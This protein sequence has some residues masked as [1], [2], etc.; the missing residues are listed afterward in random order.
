MNFVEKSAFKILSFFVIIG[1]LAAALISFQR[2][3]VENNAKTVEMVYDYKN[4]IERASVENTSTDDLFRLYKNSGITSLAVYEETVENLQNNGKIFVYKGSQLINPDNDNV[5]ESDHIYLQQGTSEDSQSVFEDLKKSLKLRIP[6]E[7][8][9]II[10][11]NNKIT[12]DVKANYSQFIHLPLGIFKT[13]LDSV[14]KA[15]FMAVIRPLNVPHMS[16]EIAE[17]LIEIID[18]SQNISA[19]LFQGKQAFGYK[20]QL[21]YFTNEL[22]KRNIP[23]A[24]IEAQNQLGFERQDGILNMAKDTNYNIIRV[25]A[26]PKDELIKITPDEAESRFYISDIER[27]IRMNLFPSY[28]FPN[29][30]KTL[31]ETNA[32]YISGVRD[33]LLE[34]GFNIGK[35][36]V[37]DF[38]FPNIVLRS[39]ALLGAISLCVITSI[40][41]LPKIRKFWFILELLIFIIFEALYVIKGSVIPLQIA[42][43]GSACSVPV[44]IVTLFI[45]YCLNIKE[46]KEKNWFKLFTESLIILWISGILSLL[47]ALFVSGLLGDVRF[48]VEMQIFRGVKLT[49]IL[50]IILISIIYIQKFPFFGKTITNTDEFTE[51]LKKFCNVP[52]KLGILGVLMLLALAAYMFI[53]RSGN[54]GAPVSNIEIQFRRLLENLLY[55]RPRQKE[56]MFGHPAVLLVLAAVYRKWPQVLHYLFIVAVTIGQGSIVETFAHMRSP[57]ILS[58]IRGLNGLLFGSLSIFII[59]ILLIFL[60]QIT[61]FFGE[62]YANK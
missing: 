24:L 43:L 59:S 23:V 39:I 15:G 34:H 50:P 5:I 11:L 54:N 49:F 7:N 41:V 36:S 31:S 28:K 38:Y 40:F 56:F 51:F 20:E 2:Y 6:S 55:A 52:I 8:I 16:K 47:G 21:S 58:L 19:V 30:E 32:C 26:M 42:A 13:D 3:T 22:K 62:K 57:Y 61:K 35:A 27:N 33:R 46:K 29:K 14:K 37:F 1:I 45:Q 44:V 60:I 17:Q 25:Y 48:L 12:I 4:I 18:Y 53:G 10:N 9:K